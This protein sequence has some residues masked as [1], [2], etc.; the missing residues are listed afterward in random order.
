[1][2]DSVREAFEAWYNEEY[3]R[4][5]LPADRTEG[6][7]QHPDAQAAWDAWQAALSANG[8]A[9][10]WCS[11]YPIYDTDGGICHIPLKG[12]PDHMVV[13][14]NSNGDLVD[15][16]G[17]DIGCELADVERWKP[18]SFDPAASSGSQALMGARDALR[19]AAKQ[20]RATGDIGHA[21]MCENHADELDR[22]RTAGDEG[23]V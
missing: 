5:I 11:G 7:Y 2:S 8:G 20:F 4:P 12:Y 17:D 9:A 15:G 16:C 3:V 6:G 19:E 1:M 22:L 13:A 23:G 10:G 14:F 18:I 21:A